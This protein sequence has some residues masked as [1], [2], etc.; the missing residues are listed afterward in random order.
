MTKSPRNNPDGRPLSVKQQRA[1]RRA[2]KVERHRRQLERDRRVRRIGLAAA[3]GVPIVLAAAVIG[4]ITLTPRPPEYTPGD[5]GI[6]IAGVRTFENEATHVEGPVQYPQDPPAGGEHSAVPLDCGVYV[7]PV[8]AENAVHSLEH[9]AIWATY[10]PDVIEGPTLAELRTLMPES[11]FI[12]SPY[13]EAA[14]PLVLSGWDVQLALD[15]F[16]PDTVGQFIEQYWLGSNAPEP[17]APCS[18]GLEA[19]GKVA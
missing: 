6:E 18:G 3:I 19:P 9:G 7:E 14:K 17:G 15:A 12:V 10:D 5:S 1:Q 4:S 8:P 16:D 2:E 13:P 11:H